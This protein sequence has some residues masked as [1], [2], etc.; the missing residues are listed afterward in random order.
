MM[1]HDAVQH[2]DQ[3]IHEENDEMVM[4]R[5][6]MIADSADGDSLD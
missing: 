4:R 3:M 2:E 6:T 5:M 1:D